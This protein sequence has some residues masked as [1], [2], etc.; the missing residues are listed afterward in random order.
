MEGELQSIVVGARFKDKKELKITCQ[1]LAT[2]ENF[3][4]SA[5]KSDK[6]QMRIK[7]LGKGCLWSL[8]ATKIVD[9]EEDP[10][11]EVKIITNEHRCFGI[12]HTGHRQA[13]ATFVRAQIQSK[14]CD[15]PS[16]RPKDIQKDLRRELGIQVSYIQAYR[17]KE[18]LAAINGTDKESYNKMPKYCEDLKWNNPGSTIV[19]ECTPEEDGHR[20]QH[21]FICYSASATGF[22][23][24]RPVLGLNSTHLKAKYY[25]ILLIAIATATDSNELLLPL[26]YT[27]VSNENNDNW[28]WFTQLLGSII[29]Q[30]APSFLDPQ[31]LTFVSDC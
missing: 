1:R 4:Y 28:L 31:R 15:P 29:V 26:A 19:L 27:V 8:S 11:F 30:Y 10:F 2:L 25:G 17:A 13:S 7:C 23:Y 9:E 21:V 14:L 24:C 5:V 3:K 18:G 20:F 16:Y 6:S 22:Q 12:L